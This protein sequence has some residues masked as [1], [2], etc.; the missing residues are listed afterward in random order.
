MVCAS[1]VG[2]VRWGGRGGVAS[3]P[4]AFVLPNGLSSRE[5][6]HVV[7]LYRNCL[8]LTGSAFVLVTF[9]TRPL[10]A[11]IMDHIFNFDSGLY[12][13]ALHGI[14]SENQHRFLYESH[15]P[16]FQSLSEVGEWVVTK[17]GKVPPLTPFFSLRPP[18]RTPSHE[19]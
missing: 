12:V 16:P 18:R 5:N 6:N 3:L 9:A 19:S 11:D 8:V 4:F 14:S 13:L 2:K 17:A 7:P 1:E 15:M 10:S